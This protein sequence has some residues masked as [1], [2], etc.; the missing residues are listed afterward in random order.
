MMEAYSTDLFYGGLAAAALA[1]IWL[2]V[3]AFRQTLWWGLGG[4]FLPPLALVFA[5]RHAQ[6][7]IGPLVAF[8]WAAWSPQ[9]RLPILYC[10]LQG[11]SCR[12]SSAPKA[13][14]L[15]TDREVAAERRRSRVDG[16]QGV[17]HA[18]RGTGHR[19][20]GVD[21]AAC[22]CVSAGSAMGAG[23][24]CSYRRW[25]WSSRHG[26]LA[27]VVCRSRSCLLSV[28]AAAVPALY[29]LYVPLDLGEVEKLVDG[30]APPHVDGLGPQGL[31]RSQAQAGRGCASDGQPGCDRR[32]PRVASRR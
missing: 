2:I 11:Q 30:A 6:K 10:H 27:R 3:R 16:G 20:A 4:L 5:L 14:A 31:L 17:L 19:R 8:I 23:Q 13:N 21:L 29:T 7:A 12:V 22:T 25:G 15:D 32:V 28:L 9:S 24:L 18:A 1:W 26:I